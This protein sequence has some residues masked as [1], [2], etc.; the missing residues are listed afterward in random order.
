MTPDAF[1]TPCGREGVVNPAPAP[2]S[3]HLDV[4][5]GGLMR[6]LSVLL[7]GVSLMGVAGCNDPAFDTT[8][9]LAPIDQILA[10]APEGTPDPTASLERRA[11][12]LRAR[13]SVLR[14][15]TPDQAAQ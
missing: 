1:E 10:Q 3:K 6:L 15:V 12:A 4:G 13:A 11:D 2:Y 8:P 5:C 9:P 14:T 7:L